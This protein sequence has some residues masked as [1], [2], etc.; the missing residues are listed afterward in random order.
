MMKRMGISTKLIALVF[1]GVAG[2]LVLAAF[3]LSLMRTTMIADRVEQVRHLTEAARGVANHYY[4]LSQRGELDRATAQDL[5]KKTLRGLRFGHDDYF[6][7]NSYD[8]VRVLFPPH[9]EVEGQSAIDQTDSN[10]VHFVR[11]VIESGRHGGQ[12]V[13]LQLPREGSD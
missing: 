2:F 7:I 11:D 8:G 12:P 1:G 5:A 9:P 13:F 4:E 3:A 10:G 6:F